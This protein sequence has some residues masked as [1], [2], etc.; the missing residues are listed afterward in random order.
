MITELSV[1][2]IAIIERA[3]LSFGSGFTVLTGET[4][5]GK[6]L[7]VDAIELALGARADAELVRAGAS[8]AMVSV[9]FDL[10]HR[11]FI[12][13]RLRELGIELEDGG[14]FVQRE[15]YAEGRSQCRIAGR[16]IPVSMLKQIGQLLVDLHGQHDHQSLLHPERHLEFLDAW[17]GEQAVG[18]QSTI[19]ER[20]TRVQEFESRLR[21]LRTG[22]REREQR[23]DML[24][25][26]VE[27]IEQAQIRPGELAEMESLL[28]RLKH[29]EKLTAACRG[30]LQSLAED[31]GNALD[32]LRVSVRELEEAATFDPDLEVRIEPIRSALYLLED[33]MHDLRAYAEALESDPE[34]LENT[35][36][37]IDT[38][39]RILKKYGD[40]EELVLEFLDS[41]SRELQ[42]LEGDESS[43]VELTESLSGAKA[44]LTK[45]CDELT[46]VRKE[47]AKTFA[48]LVAT[49]LHD[50]A[51]EKAK[52]EVKIEAKE[53]DA[54]GADAVE[55]T[56]SAN[57]GEPLRPLSKIAS[58]GEMSRV[59]LALKTVLA[60]KAG[61][62]TLIFDEV[63]SGLGGRAAAVVA[64]KLEALS[65]H[66]QVVV[67]SHVPQIA[68]RASSQLRIEK[69]E[70][71]GRVATRVVA[72]SEQERVEEIA[73]MIGGE[74][75]SESAI[76]HAKEMLMEQ[77]RG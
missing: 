28:G 67:I 29:V 57:L 45:A 6:S 37:R 70:E 12:V 73:R 41:A 47:K 44:E 24:R 39:K 25:F 59:M 60:G 54:T 19:R 38:I 1:E 3:T 56:F 65:T 64:R 7:L 42:L 17:I 72:L 8:R 21:A 51:M 69:L 20:H 40:D 66:Y 26:Q 35:A 15:L 52:F 46:R 14:L 30:G 33:G 53:P 10:T 49:E 5:A 18:L 36:A 31:E 62:P 34:V 58:G 71:R 22:Q 32:R 16:T 4:G 43:E 23:V 11:P 63:D 61:V 50:L 75:I 27:E 13:E 9:V 74:T 77:A 48:S 68:S 76:I 2:N 55:Y